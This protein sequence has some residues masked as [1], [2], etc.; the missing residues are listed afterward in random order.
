MSE[1]GI[2]VVFG[3]EGVHDIVYNVVLAHTVR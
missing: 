1:N 2:E 3:A